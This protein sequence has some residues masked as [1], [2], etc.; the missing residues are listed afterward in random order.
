M[1]SIITAHETHPEAIR[2]AI[3]HPH[4]KLKWLVAVE[5]G[6]ICGVVFLLLP[7]GSP[8]SAISFGSGAVMGRIPDTSSNIGN[9][10]VHLLLATV[11]GVIIAAAV[12]D[13]LSWRGILMGGLMGLALYALNFLVVH[14]AFPEFAGKESLV[15]F[16]HVVFGLFA[17]ALYKGMARDPDPEEL[18]G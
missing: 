13:L 11:Y 6:L 18:A 17:A 7:L 16:T 10:L 3:A 2:H 12:K 5:A 4:R 1:R 14:F 15:A 9:I 8:W